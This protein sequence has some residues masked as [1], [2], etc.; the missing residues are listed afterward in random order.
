MKR[1]HVE[2]AIPPYFII[3]IIFAL[4]NGLLW[5]KLLC[6][7][8][9][10]SINFIGI[11]FDISSSFLGMVVLSIGNALPDALTTLAIAK[12]GNAGGAISG[13]IA[14]HLFSLLI[15]L[16]STTYMKIKDIEKK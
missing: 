9:V 10:N 6:E 3:M 8:L 16:G 2:T 1:P 12:Q 13:G 7:I 15:A 4:I 5:N 11:I 14:C